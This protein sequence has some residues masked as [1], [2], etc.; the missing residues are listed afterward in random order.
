MA[1][2]T[3]AKIDWNAKSQATE[4]NAVSYYFGASETLNSGSTDVPSWTAGTTDLEVHRLADGL[5][6]TNNQWNYELF[7]DPSSTVTGVVKMFFK[8]RTGG[9]INNFQYDFEQGWVNYL[10]SVA[11]SVPMINVNTDETMMQF[12]SFVV[13]DETGANS[14]NVLILQLRNK[15]NQNDVTTF[16]LTLAS[17]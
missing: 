11:A 8:F 12:M 2:A 9:S 16:S 5:T 3:A 17:A 4:T 6:N 10:W 15:V 14:G 13:V 7:I 1:T